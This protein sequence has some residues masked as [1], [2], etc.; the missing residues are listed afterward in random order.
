MKRIIVEGV[1][2]SQ[3][4]LGSYVIVLSE[5]GGNRK[6]PIIV[7]TDP[8]EAVSL[9]LEGLKPVRR[10]TYDFVFSLLE[11]LDVR[12]VQGRINSF[13][14]GIFHCSILISWGLENFEIKTSISDTI[15]ISFCEE[16]DLFINESVLNSCGI[17]IDENGE[18]I[19]EEKIQVET[20]E[21]L[22]K[23]LELAILEEDYLKAAQIRD[24]INKF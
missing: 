4:N 9:K 17:T 11:N 23:E 3:S 22:E 24:K 12:V 13:S 6:I 8:A 19:E 21:D 15:T 18:V 16:A 1:S 20:K 14:E 7:D 5:E 10:K 2:Y